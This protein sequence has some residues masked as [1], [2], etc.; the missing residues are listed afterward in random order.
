[1]TWS[2]RSD[3]PCRV[4]VS[5][6]DLGFDPRKLQQVVCY[7]EAAGDGPVILVV[8]HNRSG[9]TKYLSCKSRNEAIRI[10]KEYG[11]RLHD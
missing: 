8:D 9:W 1:M 3:I 4:S 5:A 7:P 10:L 11:Y 2:R 6:A